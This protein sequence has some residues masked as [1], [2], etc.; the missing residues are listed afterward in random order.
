MPTSNIKGQR[1]SLLLSILV[2]FSLYC[3]SGHA[4]KLAPSL[5]KISELNKTTYQVVWR[6]PKDADVSPQPMFPKSCS[7]N[8]V[9]VA[10]VGTAFEYR[11]LEICNDGLAGK[12][13]HIES[14]GAS[15]TVAM[16][17]F[18][19]LEEKLQRHILSA[20]A[21]SFL[22][23]EGRGVNSV[24][25]RYIHIG[26]EHILVG[27]DHLFFVTALLLLA[28]SWRALLKTVTAFTL[29][30]SVTLALVSLELMPH[31]PALV[32]FSIAA[33]IFVLALELSRPKPVHGQHS[34]RQHQWPVA[35]I[36]GLIHGLGFAGVLQEI[37]LPT[38]DVI[39]ALIAFNI[40][41]ELGQ[42]AFVGFLA[43]LFYLLRRTSVPIYALSRS[44]CVLIIGGVSTYW[45]LDRGA[46][47]LG[48][49][50]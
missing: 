46:A 18:Q 2:I 36:F 40:G 50:L 14:L 41:I 25:T 31:W 37:G 17:D 32:E 45:G 9:S 48:E 11:W 4:H 15:R 49:L 42:L 7:R 33:T 38:R 6:T 19:P 8:T 29:G 20:D 30:H 3:P 1:A 28:S 23:P 21:P 5:L 13:I 27:T 44:A 43:T 16:L 34:I 24:F 22:V 10:S 26:I 39:P 47:L 12:T 35:S